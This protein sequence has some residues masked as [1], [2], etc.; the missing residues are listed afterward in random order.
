[1]LDIRWDENQPARWPDQIG[2]PVRQPVDVIVAGTTADSQS[3]HRL[4]TIF[5]SGD[6]QFAREGG[7][8]N[9]GANIPKSWHRASKY[10]HKILKGTRPADLP[11]SSGPA[12]ISSSTTKPRTRSV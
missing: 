7:L 3:S 8:M 9:Y 10:V 6:G 12:S 5:G 1:M 4:P 11:W 2:A